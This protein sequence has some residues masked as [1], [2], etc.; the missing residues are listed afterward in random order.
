MNSENKNNSVFILDNTDQGGSDAGGD[1]GGGAD[2][3]GGDGSDAGSS[4]E[5]DYVTDVSTDESSDVPT[6]EYDTYA[7]T[8]DYPVD[9]TTTDSV[10]QTTSDPSQGPGLPPSY[11]TP[12]IPGRLCNSLAPP[13]GGVL[14]GKCTPGIPN[15]R[16]LLI[17]S[18][19]Y[20]LIGSSTVTCT[21]KGLWSGYLGFCQ[22]E[23][24]V[25]CNL[26]ID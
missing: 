5:P 13:S 6:E 20:K 25:N 3:V 7:P 16:C 19:G 24:I 18:R 12:S 14:I 9:D 22:S 8:S 21:A 17:C 1:G 4:T 10:D 26:E 11:P 23:L 15:F 2:G